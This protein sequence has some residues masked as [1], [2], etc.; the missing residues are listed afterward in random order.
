[1]HRNTQ[2]GDS[3]H[4]FRLL[5]HNIFQCLSVAPTRNIATCLE[6]A[7]DE[8]AVVL[9]AGGYAG[10]WAAAIFAR[11]LCT[12]HICEPVPQYAAAIRQRFARNPRLIV[13]AV[14]LA[15]ADGEASLAIRGPGSSV[16]RGGARQ[17][18]VLRGITR[19]LAEEGL[20]RLDLVKLNIEGGEYEV[21]EELLATRA[22]ETIRDLQVQFHD[23]VPDAARRMRRIQELL[24]RTHTLTYQ[25]PFVW[26]NWR[27][28]SP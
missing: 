17:R 3:C 11:Y 1:M 27:R 22:I 9:D 26:E 23:V 13:H 12:V 24:A 5:D 19:F 8:H 21:L 20:A 2:A 25:F 16:Y 15:G 6:Y 28:R 4:G 7:L 10:D 18:V 14:G